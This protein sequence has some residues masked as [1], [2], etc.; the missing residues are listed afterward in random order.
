[1][2]ESVC[3]VVTIIHEIFQFPKV[4]V[5]ISINVSNIHVLSCN[6]SRCR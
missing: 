1:M 3:C 6:H 5:C 4:N 2:L